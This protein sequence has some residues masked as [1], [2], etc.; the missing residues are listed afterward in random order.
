M[1]RSGYDPK[2]LCMESLLKY[3]RMELRSLDLESMMA[4]LTQQKYGV[5]SIQ[6]LYGM[7]YVATFNAGEFEW[8][9]IDD[10]FEDAIQRLY[11]AVQNVAEV[12]E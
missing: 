8:Q 7:G 11:D 5:V 12:M 1:E 10:R 9:V 2:T 4:I 6:Y 3:S